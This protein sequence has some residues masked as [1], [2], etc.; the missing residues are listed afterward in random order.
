M[1]E[2]R[3][4]ERHEW[5]GM[6]AKGRVHTINALVENNLRREGNSYF[7]FVYSYFV[8]FI[9]WDLGKVKQAVSETDNV[10]DLM[11][12]LLNKLDSQALRTLQIAAAIG[13]RLLIYFALFCLFFL[14]YYYYG[15]NII[16]III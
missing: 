1:R 11:T 3:E 2:G 16:I 4:R 8:Y 13:V 6:T 14:T 12:Q 10:I 5:V 15:I 7:L 9:R